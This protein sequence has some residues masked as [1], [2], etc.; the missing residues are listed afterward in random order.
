MT[1]ETKT[2]RTLPT[3]SFLMITFLFLIALLVVV[4]WWL[5]QPNT[6]DKLNNEF[7]YVPTNSTY[8][9]LVKNL[10]DKGFI[11]DE[12][13]FRQWSEWLTFKKPR[14]GRF[15][16][17]GGWSNYQLI[18][19]LQRGE[20]SPVN[21]ILHNEK[22]PGEVAAKVALFIEADSASLM[23]L[24]SDSTYLDSIGY[25]PETLMSIFIPNTY[26]FFW[27]TAP[28][29]FME[30]MLKE[31]KRFWNDERIQKAKALNLTPEQVYTLASII[32]GESTHNDE[33]PKIA[34]AY[35]N[36][37]QQNVK[38]QA[39]PTVQFALI[40][41]YGGTY[42]RL[43]NKDYLFPHPYNTYLHEGLPPGP[44]SMAS[45]ADI[46]AVL[47]LEHHNY[48]FFCAKPDQSGYHVFSETYEGHLV[49]VRLWQKYLNELNAASSD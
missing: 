35:Y 36:R 4:Y 11:L 20:Q 21:V 31:H 26:S 23:Q 6:P 28:R 14:A 45:I 10:S 2:G 43:L 18:R 41:T 47:N 19:Q 48:Q 25:T 44:I 32:D 16:V 46:D 24:F 39:D 15:R 9:D 40:Q 8:D 29:S 17:K 12:G 42:R 7:L 13:S 33:K 34:G 38:L 27:N 37:L 49:N 1:Q 30:R 22:L 5:F 3:R